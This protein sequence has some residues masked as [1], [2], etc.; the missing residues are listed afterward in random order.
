MRKLTLLR[1]VFIM[2]I[3][4]ENYCYA[5]E[6]QKNLTP[7][8]NNEGIKRIIKRNELQREGYE[9]VK[10]GL[11]EDAI[12]KYTMAMDPSLLNTE[13]DKDVA[14]CAIRDIYK[15]QG[16]FKE[17]LELNEKYILPL[18]PKKNSYLDTSLELKSLIKAGDEKNNKPVYDYIKYLKIKYEKYIPPKGYQVI[19]ENVIDELIYLYDYMHDYDSG[20]AFMD[21]QIKYHTNHP[22]KNHK[23]ANAKR[24]KEY[25]RVKQAWELDKNTGQHGHL[26]EVIKTSDVISW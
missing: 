23:S 18:N 12:K 14:L 24:V 16:K 6:K 7:F 13:M 20:I 1:Y 4:L 15:Y 25:T 21:E 3:I 5:I 10:Q 26:K 19:Y 17:A 9:L 22:D 2:I 11:Y 8:P